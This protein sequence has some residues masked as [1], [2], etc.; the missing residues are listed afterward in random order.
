MA[1]RRLARLTPAAGLR[2]LGRR[3]EGSTAVEFAMVALPFAIMM[4]SVVE[5]A[6]VFVLDS[7]LENAVIETGR[8]VRTGQASAAGYT[9]DTFKT[10]VCEKMSIFSTGC[11][12]K[13]TVDVR[14]I[15]QFN[16]PTLPDPLG[17]SSFNASGLTYN[18]GSPDNLML[19]RAWYKHTLFTPFLRQG[20][21]R[22][23]TDDAYLTATTA[24]RNEP[25]NG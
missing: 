9:A 10:A 12:A 2:A 1:L 11:S 15:P 13:L 17:G 25:W 7:A 8:R 16:N 23:G 22:L 4:F 3:R 14:V 18:N 21:S 19:I 20:L 5:I 6:F 24:F